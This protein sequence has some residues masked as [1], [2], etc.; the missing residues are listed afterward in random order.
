MSVKY[1]QIADVY[2]SARQ[3]YAT[4]RFQ[5]FW[6]AAIL[7][8]AALPPD[9][10][11]LDCMSGSCEFARIARPRVGQLHAVD[12]SPGILNSAN[13]F[14]LPTSRTCGDAHQLPFAANSFDAVFVIGGLHHQRLTFES[15][16]SEL[17]RVLKPDGCLICTEPADDN[18][19]IY[20][21]RELAHRLSDLYEAGERGFAA[22][23]LR[24]AFEHAGFVEVRVRRSGYAAYTL[25]GN[26]D[27]LPLFARLRSDFII[28]TLISVDRISPRIPLWNSLALA[29][30]VIG[31]AQKS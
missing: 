7:D 20:A 2:A 22:N 8:L 25:I 17:H 18:P 5:D 27:V 26:T 14:E 29:L 3:N 1:D 19:A 9:A 30:S 4:R 11:V 13:V 12:I 15:I 10:V 31:R 21:L 6:F 24:S 23:D 16:L 28:D